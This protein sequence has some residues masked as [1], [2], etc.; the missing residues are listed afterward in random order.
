MDAFL[1]AV[2]EVAADYLPA[3]QALSSDEQL[4]IES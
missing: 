1:E 3:L 4:A 2:A